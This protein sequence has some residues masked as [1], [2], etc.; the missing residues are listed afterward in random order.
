MY[1]EKLLAVIPESQI[2]AR[3]RA[4][5]KKNAVALTR[6]QS[7]PSEMF[8]RSIYNASPRAALP[9]SRHSAGTS[10]GNGL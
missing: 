10:T 7:S 9:T 6:M 1:D 3:V 5:L 2:Q 4:R 8:Y